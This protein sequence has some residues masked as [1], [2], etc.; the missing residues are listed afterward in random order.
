MS[1]LEFGEG[2]RLRVGTCEKEKKKRLA[3]VGRRR[4]VRFSEKMK[5]RMVA[6]TTDQ[7]GATL[8]LNQSSS[9]G[10]WGGKC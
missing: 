4:H 3:R 6:S 2:L 10:V 7:N 8:L 5:T 9:P 1:R